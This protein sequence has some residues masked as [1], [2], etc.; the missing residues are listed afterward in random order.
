MTRR[1]HLLNSW[2]ITILLSIF[3]L[4]NFVDKITIGLVVVPLMDEFKLTPSQ[5]GLVASSF[6]WL[7][8]LACIA[9]GFLANRFKAKWLILGMALIW[10]ASQ[11]PIVF[12]SSIATIIAARILLGI[13]EGP[14]SPVATHAVFKWFP[15]ERRNLPVTA[16][17]MGATVGLLLAGF[18]IPYITSK[19][20]WRTNFKILALIGAIWSL[21]WFWLGEEGP[22]A[23]DRA[24]AT[25]NGFAREARVPY[26]RL[27]SDPTIWSAMILYFVA[28]WALALTLTWLP[29][30]IQKGLGFDAVT[31]GK[32]FGMVVIVSTPANLLVSWSSQCLLSRGKSS[33]IS[34]G[35]LSSLVMALAGILLF[36]LMLLNL[37]PMQKVMMLS[38]AVGLPPVI[39]SL[40]PGMIGELTPTSQR[41]AMLAIDNAVATLAAV[42]AP[43]VTG[44]LIESASGGP[45]ARGY[46]LGFVL[47]GVLLVVG[48]LIGLIWTNPERS[49]DRLKE[50]AKKSLPS[51]LASV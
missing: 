38:V 9:G 15:N 32:L 50:R 29:A 21:L 31:S 46:E 13:G 37:S 49:M 12:S 6:F 10:S 14:A 48:A 18:T 3:M 51:H 33:R 1:N 17:L 26:R 22:I 27:L 39:Y 24:A 2:L 45:P 41:G 11:V 4:V 47:N 28:Y 35:V 36:G 23:D 19:W 34:R 43:P 16:I 7:F 42:L 40:A 5:F 30:Y 20:G 44:W 8:S 25:T